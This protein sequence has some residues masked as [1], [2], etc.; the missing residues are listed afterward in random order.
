MDPI[1]VDQALNCLFAFL[2]GNDH[3]IINGSLAFKD[4]FPTVFIAGSGGGKSPMIVKLML[5][6]I[7]KQ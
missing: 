7:V 1:N 6:Q 5:E 2:T 4:D 3:R